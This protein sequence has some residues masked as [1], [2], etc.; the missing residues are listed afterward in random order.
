MRGALILLCLAAQGPLK[1]ASETAT[2]FEGLVRDQ[3]P[4]LVV[5]EDLAECRQFP[6]EQAG[7]LDILDQSPELGER[8]LDRG[9]R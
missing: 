8:I 5:A 9:R 1:D 3:A 4:A 2:E 6:E 7:R